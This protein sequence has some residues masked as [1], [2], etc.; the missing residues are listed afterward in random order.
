MLQKCRNKATQTLQEPYGTVAVDAGS[1]WDR[2]GDVIVN[3]LSLV[4]LTVTHM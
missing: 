3:S 4:P 1:I 2:G